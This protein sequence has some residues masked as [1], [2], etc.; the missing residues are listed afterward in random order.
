MV[1]R[2]GV[3]E[4]RHAVRELVGGCGDAVLLAVLGAHEAEGAR[5]VRRAL[6]PRPERVAGEEEEEK[7]NSGDRVATLGRV[8]YK[9]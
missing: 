6:A 8:T 7:E 3:H 5:Q 1:A 4:L 9:R 2:V